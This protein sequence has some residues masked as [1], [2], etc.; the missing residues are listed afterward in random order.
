MT[1]LTK[2]GWK[3]L[4]VS[5]EDVLARIKPGMTIFLGSG[6]AEPRTLMK[7]L[8]DSGLSNTN[9]LELIQLTSHSDVLSLKKR[10]WQKYRLKTFFSTMVTTEA[11]VAGSVDLI[12]G[13]I[14]QIP[15]II[16][17]KRIPINVAFIQ[18]TP[19]NDAGYCS[20]GVAVDIAR[21]AME[22]ASLVVGEINR[23][24]PFTFGDT[25]VSVADFDLLVESTEP[26]TYFKRWPVNTVIDKVAANIA[27]VIEDGDCL[28]FFTGSLFEALGRHLAHKRHLGIHSSYFTDALMDLV[29]SG[30]VTNYRK[31][32]FRGK[33]IASYALGTPELMAWLN[34]NPLVEFQSIE[35]VF[36]P[37]QI[38][39]NP[40]FVVVDEARKVDLLGRIA[41]PAGKGNIISGPGQVADLIT[42]AEISRGGHTVIGLPS[43]SPKGDPNIVVM[44]RNLRNQFHMRESI[45][46]VVTE[47]GV[48]NLKWRTIR[49]RAQA[50]IDIAHPEDRKKLVEQAKEKKIL[51][52]DQIFLSESAHLYPMDI[53]TE[54]IFRDGLKVRFRAIKPSDEE[55]MRRLFY[56]FS[57]KTVYRRFFFPISIMPH[58]KIQAYVNV[59]YSRVMSVVALVGEPDQATI[60]AE[61]RYVQD[62]KSAYG[63]LA[64]VVEEKYQGLGIATYLY[65]MLILLAKQRGLKGFS[66]EVLQP[67]KGMMKVFERGH[68]PINARLKNG[69]YKLTIPFDEPPTTA[70]EN[71]M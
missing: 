60:I 10:D 44:L 47:Y 43:R 7:S 52:K 21:E 49:E 19:P 62:E 40:N 26:P 46:A 2:T 34:R 3:D 35:Q 61:A 13:R 9:D 27:Q 14:S 32:V 36:D 28:T 69:L 38:G 53:A 37:T 25:I 67:N 50:L 24:I 65:E 22:Q 15:R 42:G 68:L 4:V 17:S 20:L 55:A 16:K 64:F 63:D 41:F 6:V 29:K 66:A 23:Q 51:F 54:H 45:D 71:N 33:S 5:A 59:D 18:I 58:D 48:A 56:R 39:R 57:N 1:E 30:A 12:P 8:I 11:V 31:A 70:I